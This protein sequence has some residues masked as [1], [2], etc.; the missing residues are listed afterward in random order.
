MIFFFSF[1][2]RKL[3]A[4]HHIAIQRK[5]AAKFL[6]SIDGGNAGN[7]F[8]KVEDVLRLL[9]APNR[10]RSR[11]LGHVT[12]HSLVNSRHKSLVEIGDVFKR[13]YGRAS[14][15]RRERLPITAFV[16]GDFIYLE[17]G[18]PGTA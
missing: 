16:Y 3:A 12:V 10:T 18:R 7:T 15:W 1:V 17:I 11:T 9:C 14:P 8:D 4:S 2:C 13:I 5:L 6:A